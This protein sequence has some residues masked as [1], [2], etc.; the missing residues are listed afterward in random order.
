MFCE[1][2]GAQLDKDARFCTS[3]GAL[4][5]E[6]AQSS[7]AVT[8]SGETA[9]GG[10]SASPAP[11]ATQPSG[12]PPS[13]AGST[14]AQDGVA[15]PKRRMRPAA[16]AGIAVAGTLLVG[17]GVFAATQL[18]PP[19][20]PTAIEASNPSKDDAGKD[21]ADDGA[22]G[23]AQDTADNGAKTDT[24]SPTAATKALIDQAKAQGLPVYTGTV[25][26]FETNAQLAEFQGRT[27]ILPYLGA[28]GGP[29]AILD[30]G[31]PVEID[32]YSGDGQSHGIE[33]MQLI[34]LGNGYGDTADPWRAFDGQQV[35]VTWTAVYMPSDVSL[36][37]EAGRAADA[38]ALDE[39][40]SAGA[41]SA[42]AAAPAESADSGS[43]ILPDS[44][45]RV[46]SVS[47]LSGLSSWQLMIARN[48]I[49]AR[50]GRGF[51]DAE[52]RSYFQN[53]SWYQQR[54]TAEEFDAMA[55]TILSSIEQQ[56]IANIL[57]VEG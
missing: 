2:C 7:A 17:V 30:L 9:R 35:S 3:C 22:N 41:D 47:E 16:I 52:V 27:D 15:A 44:A 48:E 46:Y 20:D 45:T 12:E 19:S 43:Y 31:A 53:Q 40:W 25:R 50:H 38:R 11:V 34:E 36:P 57:E 5:S 29:Y 28:E 21:E 18:V 1:R 8:R 56:N 51:N 14:R 33:T 32:A 55:S 13:Q 39:R 42:S 49:Y 23:E 26:I 24:A 4:V 10:A 37:V 6:T 54:Y